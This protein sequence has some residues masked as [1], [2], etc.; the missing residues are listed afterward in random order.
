M[1]KR[2]LLAFMLVLLITGCNSNVTNIS[3]T[4][5]EMPNDFDFIIMFG[6]GKKNVINTYENK[7]TKDLIA[8]GTVTTNLSF[9]K[10]ELALIYQK[11][12]E[13]DIADAKDL[14]PETNCMKEP[15]GQDEIK[16]TINGETFTHSF[17][18]EYC[19]PTQDAKQLIELKDF[20]WSIVESEEEYK[21]LPDPKGGYE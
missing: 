11:M 14:I 17:S 12:K 15:F 8:D 20:V 16:V 1:K 7:V 21:K 18:E 5:S 2:Y 3:N 6:V 10:E 19:E 9:S 4:S 13:I